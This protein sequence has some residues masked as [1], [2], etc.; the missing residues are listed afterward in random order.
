MTVVLKLWRALSTITLLS[1]I[2]L[3]YTHSL[4]AAKTSKNEIS[5]SKIIGEIFKPNRFFFKL[6]FPLVICVLSY[7]DYSDKTAITLLPSPSPETLLHG[8]VTPPL[9]MGFPYRTSAPVQAVPF[10]L[11]S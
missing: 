3:E 7:Q 9:T 4:N 10:L 11:N 6:L 5:N 8:S 2:I 1:I